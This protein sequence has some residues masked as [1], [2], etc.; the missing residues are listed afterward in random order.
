MQIWLINPYGPLPQEGWRDYR[1]VTIGKTLAAQGH[2]VVWWTSTFSHHFKKQRSA[3]W[4]TI[5]ITP[6][7]SVKLVPTPGYKS[8]I[9][10]A[11]FFRDFVFGIRL[12]RAARKEPGPDLIVYCES[13]LQF[14]YAAPALAR[15]HSCPVIYDQI[16]LWPELIVRRI[17]PRWQRLAN[18]SFAPVYWHRSRI[19]SKVDGVIALAK[20]YL[21]SVLDAAP[22]TK[23][24]PHKTIYNGIDVRN[25][26]EMIEK[27]RAKATSGHKK[28]GELLA[29]F[30]GSLGPSYDIQT[31]IDAAR[32]AE[33]RNVPVRLVIAGDGPMKAKVREAS[34]KISTLAYVGH[35]DTESLAALYA[36][37]DVG[38]SCYTA[39]TNVEMPDK[40][41]DYTAANLAV[42]N[43]LSGEVREQIE[44]R[45]CGLQYTPGVHT[46]LLDA[47]EKLANDP[48]RLAA[49][50][51][52]SSK[53]ALDFDIFRQYAELPE[54]IDKVMSDRAEARP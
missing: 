7:F 52:A 45:Q 42:I 39:W 25:F 22:I 31:M 37:A 5:P 28:E 38:L 3:T 48:E 21:Q 11:R 34:D 14:G 19:W 12:F 16:D 1:F 53:S 32:L 13:P 4:D 35:L 51:Q 40:F 9:S 44:E 8:N 29:V 23:R 17:P 6:N 43:S 54:F 10:L 46:E 20:P 27:A 15:R 47:L 50:R 2:E 36:E 24:K 33:S 41:Y 18:M 26:Q 49:M 30:A